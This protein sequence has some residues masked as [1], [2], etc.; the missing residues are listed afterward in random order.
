MSSSVLQNRTLADAIIPGSGVVRDVALV[1][2]GA[3]LTTVCAQVSI[4]WQPVPFTLQTMAV[5]LCGLGL[6]K[7]RGVL[8]QLVYVS[9]GL[10][11]IPVFAQGKVG[12]P[13]IAGPTG[14][15]LL[16]FAVVAW[17]LGTL[18]ERGW[19]QSF[20]KTAA[21]MAIGITVNLGMGAA[22]LSAFIGWKTAILTGVTPFLIAEGV[23]ALVV[24]GVLPSAWNFVKGKS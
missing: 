7:T 2:G 10:A 1:L 20:H 13:I 9:A 12:M 23:K 18:A 15:Y 21:A 14:G 24:I 17:L 11:G 4:P 16:S 6:G 22:W 5:M 19:T 3:V 8:S